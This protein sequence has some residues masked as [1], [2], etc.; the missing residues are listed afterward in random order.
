VMS[1]EEKKGFIIKN[2]NSVSGWDSIV[3]FSLENRCKGV[4]NIRK[5]SIFLH[6]F[7]FYDILPTFA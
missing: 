2:Q 6:I 4:V 7:I 3:L 5:I 1:L